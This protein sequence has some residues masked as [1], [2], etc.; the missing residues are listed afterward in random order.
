MNTCENGG[1][2]V[3]MVCSVMASR[4]ISRAAF[5]RL[6]AYGLDNILELV[7]DGWTLRRI[8]ELD[9]IACSRPMLNTWLRGGHGLESPFT[10]EGKRIRDERRAAYELAQQASADVLVEDAG[11]ILDNETDGRNAALAKA[12]SDFRLW[13]AARRNREAY[14]AKQA[15]GL[16]INVGNLHLDSLRKLMAQP[17]PA[18]PALAEPGELVVEHETSDPPDQLPAPET[19]EVSQPATLPG[20]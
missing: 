18:P 7:A 16:V 11:E 19:G 9:G 4:P 17:R 20:E 3:S 8:A 12:R 2:T 13:L 6:E 10:P 15:P 14:D 5:I 1:W